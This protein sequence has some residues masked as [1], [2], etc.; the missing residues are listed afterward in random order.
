KSRVRALDWFNGNKTPYVNTDLTGSL[1]G[2]TLQ[3]KPEEIFRALIE[4]TAFDARQILE[5]MER[6]E[7]EVKIREV[8]ASGGI[9]GKNPLILQIYADILQRPVKVAAEPQ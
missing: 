9:A 8:T 5:I 3:T 2:L 7:A 6:S 1:A 4:A